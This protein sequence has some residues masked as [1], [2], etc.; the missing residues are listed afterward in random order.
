MGVVN[1][2]PLRYSNF[3]SSKYE[4]N[5]GFV[6]FKRIIDNSSI[7]PVSDEII[8]KFFEEKKIK[9][10]LVDNCIRLGGVLSLN[11]MI[12]YDDA[13]LIN[14]NEIKEEQV[15]LKDKNFLGLFPITAE[16][17]NVFSKLIYN[18]IKDEPM[19]DLS[20]K[21]RFPV[22]DDNFVIV[23][24]FDGKKQYS[25][26]FVEPEAS[27]YVQNLL[28]DGANKYKT[29]FKIAE[30]L[31]YAWRYAN[32]KRFMTAELISYCRY[33]NTLLQDGIVHL[34]NQLSSILK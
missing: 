15:R 16:E 20:L 11:T 24:Y 1:A 17:F 9:Y 32:L 22:I 2:L 12:Y 34:D 28:K 8:K 27:I 26:Y 14:E 33:E 13:F 10:V 4:T 5:D 6:N 23:T 19:C 30:N 7:A 3:Y 29:E 21:S 25:A 31:M 18:A